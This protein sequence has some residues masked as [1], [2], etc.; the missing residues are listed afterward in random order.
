MAPPPKGRLNRIRNIGIMA[1]ID[2]GKTTVTERILYYTGRSYKMGEVH[3]GEAVMDWMPQEQERGI[4][5]TSAVT[6]FPWRGY[7]I[8]LIDTPGHVDFT[9]EVER[10][11]RVL[12]GAIAVFDAVNG[13]EPQSETV[14]HQADKY[15]VPRLTFVNKMDRVGADFFGTVAM[16]KEKLGARPALVQIPWGAEDRF[17]GVI[18]LIKMKAVIWDEETLG[19]TFHEI[20]IPADF[21]TAAQKFRDQLLETLAEKNDLLMEKYLSGEEITSEEIKSVLRQATLKFELVPVLCG[22]ALRNKGIQPLLDAIVDYLPSPLDVPPITGYNPLTGKQ[23]TRLSSEKEPLAA[24]AFKIMMDE[25]RKLTY[26][27]VYSGTLKPEQEVYNSTK[28]KKERVA[29]LFRMHANKKE[30]IAEVR[31]GDIVAAAGLK[32]TTTGDTLCAEEKPI[33]LERIEFYEPVT[34]MAIEP[35]TRADQEKLE[36]SLQKIMEEDPTFRVKLDEDTGQTIISGMGELHL[37]VIVRRLLDD[38]GV[39]VNM[40]RPQVVYRET[41]TQPAEGEGKFERE[42]DGVMHFGHVRLFLEPKPRGAGFEFSQAMAS[43]DIPQE[44]IPAIEAGVR[45]SITNGVIS[46]YPVVDLRVTLRGG[47]FRENQSSPL[48]YQIAAAMAFREGCQK[49][50]PILLEP[51]MKTEVVVPEEFLGEVI[52]DLSARKGRIEQVQSRGKVSVILAFVPLREMFGYSTDLRSLSQGRGSFT[53]QFYQFDRL[54]DKK[55]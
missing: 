38:F 35:K 23:E 46:G 18:D 50:Q 5:I 51:I 36:F 32:E 20:E 17:Q 30:R 22:A 10:S 25:G 12:D 21:S 29:R 19:A 49:G 54:P 47:T 16:M 43:E 14:W 4:T 3:D 11:L 41:I 52:G 28:G 44:F 34:S 26:L 33:I 31:A 40:G 55:K 13:V 9:I 37:E 6:T 7:E 53:M 27:R 2:A 8:H 39:A 24:L 15:K 48:A 42:I 1:H 45:E